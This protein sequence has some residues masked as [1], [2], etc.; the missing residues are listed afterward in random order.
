[1]TFFAFWVGVFASSMVWVQLYWKKKDECEA[2]DQE[3]SSRD[4]A[5]LDETVICV[6]EIEKAIEMQNSLNYRSDQIK[7]C[8][9]DLETRERDLCLK[10]EAFREKEESLT[11]KV[12]DLEGKL[13]GCRENG[14]R[15]KQKIK[16]LTPA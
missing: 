10:E 13:K 5:V 2:K 6:H 1:M 16:E 3:L 14:R 11:S 9:N 7:V 12:S 4:D 15:L 8:L